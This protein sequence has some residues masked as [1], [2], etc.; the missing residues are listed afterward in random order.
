[1]LCKQ[2]Y[3]LTA[4]RFDIFVHD[5]HCWPACI[6]G[7]R[8]VHMWRFLYSLVYVDK[9]STICSTLVYT[10]F[11]A[12][13]TFFFVVQDVYISRPCLRREYFSAL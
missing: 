8:S 6:A 4:H 11:Y 2:T 1:M 13:I 9:Y 5:V 12:I 10:C 3:L 7:P